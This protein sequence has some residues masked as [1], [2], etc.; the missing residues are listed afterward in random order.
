M[1]DYRNRLSSHHDFDDPRYWR[2]ERDSRLPRGTF[3]G[4]RTDLMVLLVCGV[5]LVVALIVVNVYH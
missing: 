2:F 5:L 1:N 4:E 3:D